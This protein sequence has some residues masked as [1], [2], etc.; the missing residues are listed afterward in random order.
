MCD[1]E[2]C[3]DFV[4]CGGRFFLCGYSGMFLCFLGGSFVCLLCSVCSVFVIDMWVLVGLMML[5]SFLCFVVRNGDVM[6]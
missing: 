4:W 6:L 3:C 1:V 5:L 2:Y